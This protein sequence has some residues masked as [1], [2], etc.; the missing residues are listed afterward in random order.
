MSEV[1]LLAALGVAVLALPALF[2]LGR[3]SGRS[4]ELT[5]QLAANGGYDA[6]IYVEATTASRLLR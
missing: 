3:K 4:A 6:I 2:V 5:R 1:A